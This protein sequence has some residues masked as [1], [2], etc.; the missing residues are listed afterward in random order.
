MM[1]TITL[2]NVGVIT[3]LPDTGHGAP[4][5]IHGRNHH[6]KP[7]LM[8]TSDMYIN[9]NPDGSTSRTYVEKILFYCDCGAVGEY[10]RT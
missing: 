4:C 3:G 7:G 6:V 5:V 1:Q 8:V 10:T 9:H 2:T